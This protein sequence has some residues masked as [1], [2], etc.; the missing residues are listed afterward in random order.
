M[1]FIND[2]PYFPLLMNNLVPYVISQILFTAS[3]GAL[4]P[5]P[6]ELVSIFFWYVEMNTLMQLPSLRDTESQHVEEHSYLTMPLRHENPQ[7]HSKF[8]C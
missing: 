4:K 2:V 5:W 3:H 7:F 8:E 1:Q 6:T